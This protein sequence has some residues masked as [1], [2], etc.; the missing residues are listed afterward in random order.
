MPWGH[1]KQERRQLEQP[2]IRRPA[3]A[4]PQEAK[5]LSTADSF[6]S[7]MTTM[8]SKKQPQPWFASLAAT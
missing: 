4:Q 2:Q 3:K 8:K 6:E 1:P 7:S 5:R